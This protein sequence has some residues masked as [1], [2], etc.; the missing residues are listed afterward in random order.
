MIR[1]LF[2]INILIF[3]KLDHLF[4]LSSGRINFFLILES[5]NRKVMLNKRKF[6]KKKSKEEEK[7]SVL[8][9]CPNQTFFQFLFSAQT[10]KKQRE[11]LTEHFFFFGVA[12]RVNSWLRK[13]KCL[14]SPMLSSAISDS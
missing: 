6:R 8:L 14:P 5:S 11:I 7:K 9:L 4:L 1:D 12:K 13:R 2:S 3:D 10:L